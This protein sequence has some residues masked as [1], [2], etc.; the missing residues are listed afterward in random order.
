MFGNVGHDRSTTSTT[1]SSSTIFHRRHQLVGFTA[2]LRLFLFILGRRRRRRR[3]RRRRRRHGGQQM[4]RFLFG[5]LGR[6]HDHGLDWCL[7]QQFG[8]DHLLGQFQFGFRLLQL[9]RSVTCV[10]DSVQSHQVCLCF[11]AIIPIVTTR[12]SA[13]RYDSSKWV[14]FGTDSQ[15]GSTSVTLDF[16]RPSLFGHSLVT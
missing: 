15:F 12:A 9:L 8:Q 5:R 14:G 13:R 16:K 7:C 4:E 3:K 2:W 1:S 10:D 11:I 6:R